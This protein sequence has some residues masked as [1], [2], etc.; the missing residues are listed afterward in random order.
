M[1]VKK[2]I[3]LRCKPG[4]QFHFGKIAVDD[5]TSL[6]ETSDILHSDTLFSALV[7]LAAR[8]FPDFVDVLIECFDKEKVRVS[9]GFYLAELKKSGNTIFFLPKPCT[10]EIGEKNK[11]QRKV[12]FI[13]KGVWEAGIPPKKWTD[14][15]E[16]VILQKQFVV[17]KTEVENYSGRQME[18]WQILNIQTLPKV[19][20][21][22]ESK[23]DSIYF[24]TNVTIPRQRDLMI[25]IYFLIETD[26]QFVNSIEW[27]KL[28]N[29]I[30]LLGVEGIGGERSTGCGHI[31]E[32]TMEN[33]EINLHTPCLGLLSLLFP[34]DEDELNSVAAYKTFTRGGRRVPLQGSL[35]RVKMIA[36]GAVCTK[37][38][39]GRI[40]PLLN[41]LDYN[42]RRSG[43]AFT[44]PIH[45]NFV[46]K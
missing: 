23:E 40:I 6:D 9:S 25:H 45:Q 39:S 18:D 30:G 41:G 31:T 37:P 3:V 34:K 21:H 17:L 4:S 44:I 38:V 22:K 32:V 27:N 2:A 16:C 5:E 10:T 29:L 11:I 36:E 1:P 8:A 35:K 12:K 33:F 26:D 19:A 20:V 13:S 28:L 15:N 43:K 7:E 42:F 46:P 24:Q 14:K